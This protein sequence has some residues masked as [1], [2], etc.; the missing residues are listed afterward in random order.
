MHIRFFL[1]VLCGVALA[2]SARCNSTPEGPPLPPS[3][4]ATVDGQPLPIEEYYDH[5]VAEYLPLEIGKQA[6]DQVIDEYTVDIES[7]KRAVTVSNQQIEERLAE[8]DRQVRA[9]QQHSLAEELA[10]KGVDPE[11]F[12]T[13]LKKSMAHEIMARQDFKL[14][15]KEPVPPEKLKVW[16]KE[17][18]ASLAI[19]RDGLP[20][21]V[22]ALVEGKPITTTDVG[23]SLTKVLGAEPLKNALTEL[24]GIYLIERRATQSKM[25][26]TESDCDAELS[27]RDEMLKRANTVEGLSY[28]TLLHAQGRTIE[29]VKASRR[30]KAEVALAKMSDLQHGDDDLKRYFDEHQAEIVARYSTTHRVSTIFLKAVDRPNQ[31]QIR[32]FKDAEDELNALKERIAKGTSFRSLA[33]IYSEHPSVRNEGDLGFLGAS[34]QG[35]EAVYQAVASLAV[36]AVAGPVR[37][38]EG[39]HLVMLTE[40]RPQ[41][42][43]AE[44]HEEVRR[45]MRR[46]YY[47]DLFKNVKIERRY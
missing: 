25:K 31:F 45:E 17:K 40:K 32:T 34:S 18:R 26:V 37:T 9:A 38:P 2:R 7:L 47:R 29:E 43:F 42:G 1:A 14:S 46:D 16:L 36:G 22:L 15:D 21:R 20:P 10:T 44:L 41:L 13:L 12:R 3:I 19:V 6:F 28:A 39:C 5:L 30:F 11:D 27:A 4:A 24:V 35:L 23:R 8:M 33:H